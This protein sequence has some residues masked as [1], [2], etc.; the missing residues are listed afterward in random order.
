M[1]GEGLHIVRQH[2]VVSLDV[3]QHVHR[4][5]EHGKAVAQVT[6]GVVVAGQVVLGVQLQGL[7]GAGV[8][9][10][11]LN[12][13]HP[14]LAGGA[15]GP[16]ALVVLLHGAGDGGI[17][18]VLQAGDLQ[19]AAAL[20]RAVHGHVLGAPLQGVQHLLAGDGEQA[21]HV[22]EGVDLFAGLIGHLAG[23][24]LV[25]DAAAVHHGDVH[26]QIHVVK[27]I[28]QGVGAEVA[29]VGLLLAHQA[30]AVGIVVG[31]HVG[32]GADD[33][34]Q[35]GV[36]VRDPLV[37]DGLDLGVGGD[38]GQVGGGEQL[39]GDGA[40]SGDGHLAQSVQIGAGLGEDHGLT[41][42]V[43]DLTALHSGVGMAVDEGVQAGGVG[44][45]LLAGPGLGGGVVT[46]VAQSDDVVGVVVGG[47]GVDGGLHAE[48][49]IRAV[50]PAGDV[51]DVLALLVLEVGGGGLG[52]GLGGGDAHEGDL[53]ARYLED[54]HAVQHV[55]H[56]LAGLGVD[57][58]EVAGDIG[59]LAAGGDGQGPGHAV[60]E[61]MVAQGGQVVPGGLHQ[62]DDGSAL[63]H[64]A[65]GGALDV[66]AGVHQQ[67]VS[68]GVPVAGHGGIPQVLVDVG[69]YVV[70]VQNGDSV[71]RGSGSGN[72]LVGHCGGGQ[73]EGRSHGQQQG[74][75]FLLHRI[76]PFCP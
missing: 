5:V 29:L 36:D 56:G 76:P 8:L 61:L 62:L 3:V 71:C 27:Q 54:L 21:G 41:G 39:G 1:V 47:H 16:D 59:H 74:K 6:Q 66:V 26:V 18:G 63:V 34:A 2:H 4:A 17:D 30:V 7:V 43:L 75:E 42:L 73:A 20:L 12:V 22:A 70:G 40:V 68:Q 44:D 32:E 50:V 60:V 19:E 24:L 49:Q 55:G 45:Q 48:V 46:Q 35:L 37:L 25:A 72:G 51:I 28:V 13:L 52:E 33:L 10:Q 57:L 38:R 11:H 9:V 14:V 53:L 64:G 15:A 58:E 65:V 23:G 69:M 67:D 31:H